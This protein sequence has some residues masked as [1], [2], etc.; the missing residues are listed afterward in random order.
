MNL[1]D[2]FWA[3]FKGVADCYLLNAVIY[4]D[5]KL[6]NRRRTARRAMSVEILSAESQLQEHAVQQSRNRS[7]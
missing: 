1:L 5:K 4:S 7:K 2:S 3:D 6:C